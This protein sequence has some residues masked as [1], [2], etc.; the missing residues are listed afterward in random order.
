MST[1]DT[2]RPLRDCTIDYIERALLE[3]LHLAKLHEVVVTDMEAAVEL[4][5]QIVVERVVLHGGIGAKHGTSFK[6]QLTRRECGHCHGKG[7]I[8]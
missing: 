5:E 6:R 4:E 2:P 1:Y 3:A 7:Y 8:G